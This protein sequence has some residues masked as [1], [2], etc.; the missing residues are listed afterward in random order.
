MRA[1]DPS[2]TPAKFRWPPPL[3]EPPAR[4]VGNRREDLRRQERSRRPV[5]NTAALCFLLRSSSP[6]FS[7]RA[8]ELLAG[9]DSVRIVQLITVGFDDLH[10]LFRF[11]LDMLA[12][13][14]ER[15]G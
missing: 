8:V 4:H 15:L 7:L 5:P 10:V 2:E 1:S 3:A 13:L 6:Y 14:R 12:C 9:L 11:A